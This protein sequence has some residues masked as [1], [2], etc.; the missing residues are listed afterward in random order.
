M[1]RKTTKKNNLVHKGLKMLVPVVCAV[2]SDELCCL[3]WQC[4]LF[5]IRNFRLVLGL[6]LL[7]LRSG[8]GSTSGFSSEM[9]WGWRRRGEDESGPAVGRE[10]EW[11]PGWIEG[12][13]D[14]DWR[15]SDKLWEARQEMSYLEGCR[16]H[17]PPGPGVLD[18][19]DS[20]RG[21]PPCCLRHGN[22]GM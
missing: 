2:S 6:L 4:E 10:E 1:S 5:C 15:Q 11:D 19:W 20:W 9:R 14:L 12:K 16:P 17:I 8:E 13:E 21:R 22:R 18:V 7:L 3:S